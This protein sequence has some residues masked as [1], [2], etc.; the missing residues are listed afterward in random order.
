MKRS[1]AGRRGRLS[2]VV[3]VA[4]SLWQTSSQRTC[5]RRTRF[6]HNSFEPLEPRTMLAADF[7]ITEFMASNTGALLD[8]DGDSSDWIEIQNVGNSAGSL[9]GWR[10]ADSADEWTFPNVNV[11]AGGYI[12]VFASNKDRAVAG[13]ELHTNF[14]LAAEGERLA[15]LRPDQSVR[16]QF[17]PY[18][19][20]FENVSYGIVQ[21]AAPLVA[22]GANAKYR[23]PVAADNGLGTSWT[24]T[25]FNDASWTSGIPSGN[26]SVLITEVF[27]RRH[28]LV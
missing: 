2:S 19:P 23:V 28:G 9:A 21:D 16:Q 20:Q 13:S 11:A 17:N 6:R 1:L 25:S 12:T 26:R 24:Q 10:L 8:Q 27:D 14:S 15:L 22:T 4:K 18:P 3:S 5:E 7:L